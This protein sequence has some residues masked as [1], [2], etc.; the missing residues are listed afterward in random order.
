M[1]ISGNTI[2]IPGSTSGVGYQDKVI[3]A[4]TASDPH[5]K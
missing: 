4:L 5:G 1:D 3:A 2:L